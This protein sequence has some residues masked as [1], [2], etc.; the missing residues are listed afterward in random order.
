LSD[1]E[2]I[3]RRWLE[4]KVNYLTVKQILLIHSM[5]IDESGG[6]HGIRDHHALLAIESLPKQAFGGQELYPDIFQKAAVYARNIIFNHPFVDGNK[7]TA[8]TAAS[9]FLEDNDYQLIVKDGEIEKFALK[10]ITHRLNL[11][12]IANWFKRNTKKI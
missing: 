2:K 5:V 6:S 7:R 12:D 1:T 8:M 9:V 4:G 3:W 11:E 10:I